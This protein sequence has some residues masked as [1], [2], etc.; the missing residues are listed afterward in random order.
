MPLSTVSKS[1]LEGR[2]IP[3][4]PDVHLPIMRGQ[5]RYFDDPIPGK[6]SSRFGEAEPAMS[7]NR[8]GSRS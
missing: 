4:V 5:E 3:A 6:V 8:R 7:G 2:I 1:W